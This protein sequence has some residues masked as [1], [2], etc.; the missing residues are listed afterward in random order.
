MEIS[1]RRLLRGG[2]RHREFLLRKN[3]FKAVRWGFVL[4]VGSAVAGVFEGA[5][6]TT[7]PSIRVRRKGS[8]TGDGGLIAFVVKESGRGFALA[9]VLPTGAHGA[10][11][12]VM[13]KVARLAVVVVE[14]ARAAVGTAAAAR[15]GWVVEAEVGGVQEQSIAVSDVKLV[16]VAQ[17]VLAAFGEGSDEAVADGGGESLVFLL[18]LVKFLLCQTLEVG[19]GAVVIVL[20]CTRVSTSFRF[21]IPGEPARVGR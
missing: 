21:G 6:S 19:D 2:G 1:I 18:G 13:A 14:C 16:F 7:T 4:R 20:R 12:A 3:A 11:G 17:E 9:S 15:R 8:K 5:S 10:G